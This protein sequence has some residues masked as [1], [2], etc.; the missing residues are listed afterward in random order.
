[1]KPKRD[2]KFKFD[3]TKLKPF[4]TK[5]AKETAKEL[6]ISYG[7]LRQVLSGHA[8]PATDLAMTMC[9]HLNAPIKIVTT[10]II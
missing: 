9:L 7:Y 6:G 3:G 8:T 5:S 2:T 4:L 1:M 10:E